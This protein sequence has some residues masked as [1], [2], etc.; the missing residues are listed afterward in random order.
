MMTSPSDIKNNRI[1]NLFKNLQK[2]SKS[3]FYS[4]GNLSR[5]ILNM[6]KKSAYDKNK[7]F[8]NLYNQ[9]ED[10]NFYQN[11]NLP[12]ITPFLNKRSN[13]DHSTPYSI[14][15]PFELLH[16][17]IADLRRLAKSA[18]DPKYCLLIVDLFCSKIYVSPMKNRRLLVKKLKLFYEDIKQKKD[19]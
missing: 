6:A 16:A 18:L 19:R 15:K 8:V 2:D 4:V 5:S 11:N 1:Q 9:L 10:K 12:L 17:A 14:S 7:V 3:I 13:I